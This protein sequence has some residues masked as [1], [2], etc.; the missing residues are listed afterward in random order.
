MLMVALHLLLGFLLIVPF[1]I[2]GFVHLATSWR[3]PN[4]AAVGSVWHSWPRPCDLDLGAGPGAAGRIRG[5]R[6]EGPRGG[7][8]AARADAARGRRALRAAS[9]GRP[10]DPLGMG[11][12][13]E[14][15]RRRL[16]RLDGD[17][18]LPGSPVVRSQGAQGGQAVLLS[19]RSDH[20]QRQVHPGPDLDD[21][22]LL[23]EMPPGRLQGMVSLGPPLQLVQQP[24]LPIERARDAPG[25]DE[26]RRLDPGR[27][28][29]CRLPRSRAVLL[30]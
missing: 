24:G 25:L 26:D 2:F 14:R 23:P 5:P 30:G 13:R 8:L 27:A 20:G 28:L 12:A 4:K 9:P 22:R 16:R 7:I 11:E 6:P 17:A 29:V 19:F 10:A 21:G 18:A 1:L 15:G 3:R